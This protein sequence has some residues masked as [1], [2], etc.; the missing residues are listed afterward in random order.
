MNVWAKHM[1]IAALF[2]ELMLLDRLIIRLDSNILMHHISWNEWSFVGCWIQEAIHF[3][4]WVISDLSLKLYLVPH[5]CNILSHFSTSF[6]VISVNLVAGWIGT[7]IVWSFIRRSD[8][9]KWFFSFCLIF[10]MNGT[11]N[12]IV[13][14]VCFLWSILKTF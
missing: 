8:C 4:I 14:K 12:F 13:I 2:I 3:D 6:L 10:S 7:F 1:S 5:L 9:L 11:T